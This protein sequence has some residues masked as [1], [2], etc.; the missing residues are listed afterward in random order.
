M[1]RTVS[2]SLVIVLAL[3]FLGSLIGCAGKE[4]APK[5]PYMYWYYPKELPGADRA[6]EAARQAGKDRGCPV[7][8]KAAEDLKN[9]A[10]EVYA[11]CRTEEAIAMA[12]EATR[13]ANALCPAKPMPPA[14]EP[15]PA[16]APPPPPPPA[17]APKVIDRMTLIVHFDTDKSIIKE[18]DK[19]ELQRA[20]N[21]IK[22]YPGA[23]VSIEGH[24]DS[25]AS[26]QYNQKLSERRAEAV[27]NYLVKAGACEEAK[28]TSVGYGESR[29]VA[30]NKTAEGR[31]KNRR[32]E[33]L[34][35]S[36]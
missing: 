18:E 14:P 36:D 11:Q 17:P 2:K 25:I 13:K 16:P 29:P 4:L 3:C 10:Y 23:N 28:I 12:N 15:K 35:L 8:F 9:N 20:I 27:K 1:S 30:D 5:D 24:T 32:V 21:F 33:V 19:A 7:E 31:A 6:V 22:K 34:I 26:E